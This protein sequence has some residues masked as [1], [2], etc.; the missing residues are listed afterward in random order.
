M[1]RPRGSLASG[2]G[3]A[4]H[5][6]IALGAGAVVAIGA[7]ACGGTSSPAPTASS[8]AAAAS[9]PAG[10]ASS[11]AAS[12]PHLPA[13]LLGLSKNTSQQ[14]QAQ[15]RTMGVMLT[16]THA[17]RHPQV[18]FY[19]QIHSGR[20]LQVFLAPWSSK[21]LAQGA[22][23]AAGGKFFAKGIA[24]S[25]GSTDL[26]S[27]PP[28]PNGGLLECG[29]VASLIGKQFF[30]VWSSKQAV[31]GVSFIRGAA[32]SLSEAASKTAQIRSAIGA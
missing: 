22:A 9:S 30:C 7:A 28:G 26:R 1:T 32:S 17:F 6:A 15:A 21:A 23:S 10:A 3:R 5:I 31:G 24:S 2:G 29:H 20:V 14:V 11:P 25:T 4:R 13:Q 18:V 12:G 8:P 16:N 19:G 27:F